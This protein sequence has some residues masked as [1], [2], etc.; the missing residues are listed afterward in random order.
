MRTFDDRIV[1]VGDLWADFWKKRQTLD[2]AL[3][4]LAKKFPKGTA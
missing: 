3:E 1:E 2:R 4:L